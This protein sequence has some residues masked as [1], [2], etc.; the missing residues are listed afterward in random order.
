MRQDPTRD[1]GPCP[2]WDHDR[3]ERRTSN[4]I[5]SPQTGPTQLIVLSEQRSSTVSRR[6]IIY[7]IH[8]YDRLTC[9]TEP[10][11]CSVQRAPPPISKKFVQHASSSERHA[12]R[13]A[14]TTLIIVQCS[15]CVPCCSVFCTVIII[16]GMSCGLHSSSSSF[17]SLVIKGETGLTSMPTFNK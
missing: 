10:F 16:Y 4:G 3:H 8:Y 1:D 5:F 17:P 13:A 6:G 11:F 9:T 14:T 7:C 2:R 15:V 12:R